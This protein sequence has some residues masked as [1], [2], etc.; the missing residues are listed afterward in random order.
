MHV[1][2]PGPGAHGV[3]ALLVG[4]SLLA[5]GS[6]D[7]ASAGVDDPR[8]NIVFVLTD[9]LDVPQMGHARRLRQMVGD[10]GATFDNSFV[11]NSLCCPSRATSLRG[12]YGRLGRVVRLDGLL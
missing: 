6:W 2:R 4:A 1:R 5:A 11:T 9:D 3:L 8:P 12:Q 10:N 7:H